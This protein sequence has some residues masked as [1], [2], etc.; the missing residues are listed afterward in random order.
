MTPRGRQPNGLRGA[1]ARGLAAERAAFAARLRARELPEP[2]IA[3]R[4]DALTRMHAGEA[5]LYGYPDLAQELR[6][7]VPETSP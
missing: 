6:S 5:A 3:R 4:V 2:D 1:L 7:L